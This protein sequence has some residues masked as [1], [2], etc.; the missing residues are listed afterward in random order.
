MMAGIPVDF[1]LFAATLLGVALLHRHTLQVALIGL[2]LIVLYKLVFTGF[3]EG[4]GFP[5]LLG[6]LGHEWV[7]LTNLL[8]LLL[9]FALLAR[10]FEESGVPDALPRILPAGW[11]GGFVLLALSSCCRRFSTTSPRR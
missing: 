11:L 3:S 10:H 2:A 9:G 1:V 8:G 4:P 6:H 7:M 5:G